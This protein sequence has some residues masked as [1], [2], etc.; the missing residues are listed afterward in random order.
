MSLTINFVD[1]TQLA[2][3]P[4][5]R[6]FAWKSNIQDALM[7]VQLVAEGTAKD[8]DLL[9]NKELHRSVLGIL[10]TSDWFTI[11][12]DDSTYYKTSAVISVTR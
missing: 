7:D 11:D 2:I 12:G 5:T 1:G 6:F 9:G 3:T 10:G 4:E 8:G